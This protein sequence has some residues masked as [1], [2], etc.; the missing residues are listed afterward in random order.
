MNDM[1]EYLLSE[2]VSQQISK[3]Y[4]AMSLEEIDKLNELRR[5]YYALSNSEQSFIKE[6]GERHIVAKLSA[7]TVDR[8]IAVYLNPI[9]SYVYGNGQY[10][11]DF[12]ELRE[13]CDINNLDFNETFPDIYQELRQVVEQRKAGKYIPLYEIESFKICTDKFFEL[14]GEEERKKYIA[15]ILKNERFDNIEANLLML[16]Q[17]EVNV[18]KLTDKQH[19]TLLSKTMQNGMLEYLKTLPDE[20]VFDDLHIGAVIDWL[21]KS[22][23]YELFDTIEDDS[24]KARLLLSADISN[25]GEII[26]FF[27]H[28][29][30]YMKAQIFCAKHKQA[31]QSIIDAKEKIVHYVEVRD[32]FLSLPEDERTA[33]L[34]NMRDEENKTFSDVGNYHDNNEIKSSLL[35]YIKN[36]ADREKVIDSLQRFVTP[37]L[38]PYV[39]SAERIIEEFFENHGGLSQQE[40]ERMKMSLKSMDFVCESFEGKDV[41]GCTYSLKQY[42]AISDEHLDNNAI[43]LFYVLHE[44]AHAMS[45]SEYKLGKY[46]CYTVFEEGMA[47]T[48]A[49]LST[50]EYLDNHGTIEVF[51]SKITQENFE[52]TFQKTGYKFEAGCLRTM[53]YVLQQQGM[54]YEGIKTFLLGKKG[55]FFEMVLGKEYVEKFEK[56]FDGEPKLVNL[57]YSELYDANSQYLQE[58]DKKSVY[59]DTNFLLP[60]FIIQERCGVD[61]IDVLINKRC[62]NE[63][64][65]NQTYFGERK[66]YEIG[67]DELEEFS[68]LYR[69]ANISNVKYIDGKN[70]YIAMKCSELDTD[71]ITE[72]SLQIVESLVGLLQY[73]GHED[74]NFETEKQICKTLIKAI[75]GAKAELKKLNDVQEL[76]RVYEILQSVKRPEKMQKSTDLMLD[77]FDLFSDDVAECLDLLR[78]RENVPLGNWLNEKIKCDEI[79]LSEVKAAGLAFNKEQIQS[80]SIDGRD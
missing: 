23:I 22:Q 80:Q 41:R 17:E 58:I 56:S 35:E 29:D 47:D 30:D 38:E 75:K 10:W 39:E 50:L 59:Y 21:T 11:G 42:I 8:N 48:V 36:P 7:Y 79:A 67:F 6:N 64:F 51:G 45:M 16:N 53:L 1:V 54:D 62:Y 63:N 52:N 26:D 37:E 5:I 19:F 25:L 69:Q 28:I 74:L 55:K 27:P 32:E 71:D 49:Q 60:A 73:G 44:M 68:E 77:I 15:N 14:I 24:Y 4:H 70:E 57:S 12:S 61:M 2:E 9:E 78:G 40:K 13:F 20:F 65:I 46:N 72:H 31:S 3:P 66:I 18:E 43:T 34:T 33:F 76:S